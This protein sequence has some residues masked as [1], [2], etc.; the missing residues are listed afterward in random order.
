MGIALAGVRSEVYFNLT[1]KVFSIRQEGKVVEHADK[2][3]LRNVSFV[4]QQGGRQR[5]L[6]TKQK[7]VHAFCKGLLL[8]PDGR[9]ESQLMGL[10]LDQLRWA[11]YNPYAGPTF[12]DRT[13]GEPLYNAPYI[14]CFISQLT[15]KPTLSYILL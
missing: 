4:V 12:T 14:Y 15:G 13:T 3:W 5:V 2:V 9:E 7:N 10:V 8:R 6:A 1:R 11:R